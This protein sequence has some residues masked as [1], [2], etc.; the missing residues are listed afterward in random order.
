MWGIALADFKGPG[1]LW[2]PDG[3]WAAW[4]FFLLYL[5]RL[6]LFRGRSGGIIHHRAHWFFAG[7]LVGSGLGPLDGAPLS[8]LLQALT[9]GANADHPAATVA[10]AAV[11]GQVG[12]ELHGV[13][14]AVG[15][16]LP[17]FLPWALSGCILVVG[18]YGA[19]H[20][21]PIAA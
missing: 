12:G 2:A 13:V 4:V 6:G 16:V 11:Q 10:R 8:E 14:G 9:F 7:L 21:C 19:I 17:K 1:G 15:G 5:V 20:G 3:V 18:V